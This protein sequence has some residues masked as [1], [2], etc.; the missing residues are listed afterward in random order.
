MKAERQGIHLPK[1]MRVC[2]E[3]V[4]LANIF[5]VVTD[6][7]TNVCDVKPHVSI[8]NKAVRGTVFQLPPLRLRWKQPSSHMWK[9]VECESDILYLK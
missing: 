9:K 6:V 7:L 5:C 1:R 2:V 4:F 3:W 8:Q